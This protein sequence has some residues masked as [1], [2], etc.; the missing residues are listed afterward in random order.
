MSTA[1]GREIAN[2]LTWRRGK[3]EMEAQNLCAHMEI[4]LCVFD[5][6]TDWVRSD[7]G[8]TNFRYSILLLNGSKIKNLHCLFYQSRLECRVH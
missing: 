6:N 8:I 5:Q 1:G 4:L 2:E 3:D 7:P